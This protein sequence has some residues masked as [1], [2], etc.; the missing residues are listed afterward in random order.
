MRGRVLVVDDLERPRRAL[1]TELQDAGFEVVQ[2]GNGLEA[3]ERFCEHAPDAVITDMVMPRSDGLELLS[4]IRS[5]SDVPVILFTARGTV[6]SASAAFKGGAD[7]FIASPDVD[8]E[9]LVALVEKAV[10]GGQPSAPAGDLATRFVGESRPIARLRERIAGVAPLPTPVLITGESGTGRDA[11]ATAIHELGS[12]HDVPLHIVDPETFA[13]GR[14]VPAVPA[15]YLD[16]IELLAPEAQIFWTEHVTR[17]EANGFREGPRIIAAGGDAIVTR[18]GNDDTYQELRSVLTSYAIDLPPL[19][20]VREDIPAIADAMVSR[21][22]AS[23]G[24][25]VGLSPATR[26]FLAEQSWPGNARQL[27]ELLQRAIAFS[28]GRQIR[29]QVAKELLLEARDNLASIREQ[30][31]ALEREVLLVTLQQTGGNV[32]R[33]AAILGKSRA[34][35]YRLIEKHGIARAHA[36]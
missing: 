8:I 7:D 35:V 25:K 16:G 32:S 24:R 36:R 31:S 19:R 22:C 11:V 34:A 14:G 6:Q 21:I 13:P 29:R 18:T 12:A 1:A 2:A 9:D 26:A 5:R 10:G 15:V 3:W 23:V 4:R 33:T 30:K 28:R 17:A 27:E 20:T